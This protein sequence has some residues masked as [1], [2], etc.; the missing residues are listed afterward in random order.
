MY[1]SGGGLKLCAKF[2]GVYQEKFQGEGGGPR[3]R[4]AEECP[5]KVS[6]I[7]FKAIKYHF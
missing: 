5:N 3:N 7:F 2:R 1:I 4:P 6:T